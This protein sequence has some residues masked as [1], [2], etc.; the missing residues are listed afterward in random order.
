MTP[1]LVVGHR[2]APGYR[3]EL[4]RSALLLAVEQGAQAIEV[5]VVPTRD[6]ALAVR[7]EAALRATTDVSARP[8]L[9]A[10]ARRAAGGH[11][12]WYAEDLTAAELTSLHCQERLPAV[13]P[14]SAQHDGRDPVLLLPE[15]LAIAAAAGVLLVLEVKDALRGADMGLDP[16]PLIARDLAR[17]PR[18][19]RIVLESFEK[20]PLLALSQLGHP[21]VYLME[22]VGM[23]PDERRRG[24]KGRTYRAELAAA[25]FGG[26]AGV[27]LPLSLL[28]QDRVE[29]MHRRGLQVWGWT[30]RT[31]NRFLPP[32]F[33]SRSGV[34][35]PGDWRTYWNTVLDTGPDALFVDQPD[36]LVGLLGAR[37]PHH[38]GA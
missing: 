33:R 2:G 11:R 5:D 38:A 3:P 20:T 31:E 1:P 22:G 34:D 7:H 27:S 12:E 8:D 30:L 29:A 28:S 10:R 14:A 4:S 21:L 32:A 36:L 16:A 9:A 24:A 18:L 26:F 23:A 19:P 6:G 35:A 17:A 13:R 15:V 25:D 37:A